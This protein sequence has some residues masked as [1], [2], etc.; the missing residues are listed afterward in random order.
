MAQTQVEQ[1]EELVEEFGTSSE[2]LIM[3]GDVN[4]GGKNKLGPWSFEDFKTYFIETGMDLQ[5][6]IID[7]E[8]LIIFK[9]AN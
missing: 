4:Q 1:E 9:V 5:N 2:T 8:N 3:V 7:M 6:N